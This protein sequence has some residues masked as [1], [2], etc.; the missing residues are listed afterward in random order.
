M[1]EAAEFQET[2]RGTTPPAAFHR[3][4]A[5]LPLLAVLLVLLG[6]TELSTAPTARADGTGSRTVAVSIDSLTPVAPTQS[7]KITVSGTVTNKGRSTVSAGHVGLRV[8]GLLSTRS[9]IDDIGDRTPFSAGTDGPE[10]SGHTQ[11]IGKLQPGIS[12]EFTLTVP[13]KDLN[14]DRDGVY[15]LGVSFS[16]QTSDQQYDRVLGIRRTLLPWQPSGADGKKTKVT[17]LW[18]LISGTHLTARTE[19]DQQQTPIFP[20]DDLAAE[21]APGGRLQ[22]LV[23]L[24]QDLHVTWVIDP[25]LLATVEA[26]TKSYQVAG[27][28]GKD[29]PGRGQA[30]AK[31]WLSQLQTAVNGKEVV[32]LPFGDPDIASLA[33]RGG[34]LSHLQSATELAAMTVDTILQ[35]KPRT[36]F[37]WP[38]DGAID[39]SVV[40][41]GTSAG[42]HNIITRSDSLREPDG[43][44]YAPTAARQIGGGNTAIVADARLSTAFEGDMTHAG[45]A[46]LAVQRF[47]A[48]SLMINKQAPENERSIVV[49][50]QRMPTTSQAQ[51]MATALNGLSAGRWTQ[52]LDRLSDAAKAKPDPAAGR[53]VPGP[54]SYPDALRAQELPTEAFTEIQKTQR[55]LSSFKT[56]LT[57]PDR[58]VI[59]FGSAIIREMSTSWRGDPAGASDFRAAVQSYLATLQGQVKLVEKSDAT[60]SGRSAT[61]PVTVKNGLL[62]GIDHLYLQLESTQPNRLKVTDKQPVKIDGGHSQSVKFET[63]AYANGPVTV[64]AQLYTADG[65]QVGEAMRFTVHVTSITP[66]VLLVI[67]GGVLLL[68]LAGLRI[69]LKRKRSGSH[70]GAGDGPETGGE[71]PSDGGDSGGGEPERPGDPAADTGT[72]SGEPSRPGEKVER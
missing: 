45:D 56:I 6:A 54:G 38:V 41:V 32:A 3:I 15:A 61:I 8:G 72:G 34:G 14:L 33:H 11:K 9:E 24:G 13:A 4:R 63:R 12:R 18:P 30:V 58:V 27:P 65:Q 5:V 16:G 29:T 47:L 51:A 69:Y 48:Q 55:E 28:G 60:L 71:G 22:Q 20:N 50:P 52:P 31:Q 2:F 25:D 39:R 35:T 70:D 53:R 57:S 66:M 19:S 44:P 64:K 43:S 62:Q 1:A 59:P 40:D 68:V 37:A 26:M 49:A 46:S 21:L 67:A 7:D 42:A 10:L 23:A 17:F 36:D